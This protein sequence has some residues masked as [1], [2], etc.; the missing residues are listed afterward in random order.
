MARNIN[1]RAS[2]GISRYVLTFI[3]GLCCNLGHEQ[4]DQ[5]MWPLWGC[6]I[7]VEGAERH[8]SC[9]RARSWWSYLLPLLGTVVM[10]KC[11]GTLQATAATSQW[12]GLLSTVMQ[13]SACAVY[14][15]ANAS[16]VVTI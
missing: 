13:G 9:L 7:G 3:G 6:Q 10:L 8:E 14:A 15:A 2:N 16:T 11:I 4:R 5:V 12:P 1:G